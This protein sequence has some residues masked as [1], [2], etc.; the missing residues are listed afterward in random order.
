MTAPA[1]LSCAEDTL[2]LILGAVKNTPLWADA[3]V[4]H[5]ENLGPGT[6][7]CDVVLKV[8]SRKRKEQAFLEKFWARSS[9]STV[10]D[11][12]SIF[13]A[14]KESPSAFS[15]TTYNRLAY[16]QAVPAIATALDGLYV[17][18]EEDQSWTW[19]QAEPQ[20]DGSPTH[21]TSFKLHIYLNDTAKFVANKWLKTALEHVCGSHDPRADEDAFQR[22]QRIR[23]KNDCFSAATSRQGFI[24]G[25]PTL[26]S[27][28]AATSAVYAGCKVAIA[29]KDGFH[30]ATVTLP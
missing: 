2:A 7:A 4:N 12:Q 20:P 16:A 14:K 5:N 6:N 13:V 24:L 29:K 17:E 27:A 21:R 25:Y 10:E 30:E 19:D 8:E 15:I 11:R 28:Q 23:G 26:A 22:E 3:T 9:A 18:L 1:K